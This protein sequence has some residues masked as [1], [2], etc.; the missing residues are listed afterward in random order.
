[1]FMRNYHKIKKDV[2]ELVEEIV[3][4]LRKIKSVKSIILFGSY[5]RGNQ[6]PLSDIDICVLTN[7][8]ITD[9]V[10][11]NIISYSS[12]KID[13]SLFWD[14][15]VRIRYRILKEGKT[16]LNKDDNLMHNITVETM[17]EYLDF[18]HIVDRNV[19]RV[20]D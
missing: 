16:I 7:R 15:P 13:I 18:K 12:E 10:K 17:D 20:L 6:K 5:A 8:K 11:S 19:R 9:N 14:L 4:D 2:N 1:M 3:N